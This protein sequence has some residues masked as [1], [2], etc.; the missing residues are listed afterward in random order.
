MPDHLPLAVQDPKPAPQVKKK[1]KKV[2]Q[3]KAAGKVLEGFVDLTNPGIS[4]SDKEE[5]DEMSDLVF[6]FAMRMHKLVASA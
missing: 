3:V 1:K 6:G 2:G 5:E 4:E